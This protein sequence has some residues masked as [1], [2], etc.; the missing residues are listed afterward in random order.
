M[1]LF[2]GIPD[3]AMSIDG[4]LYCV[5]ALHELKY[6][7]LLSQFLSYYNTQLLEEGQRVHI[8][9]S[10]EFGRNTVTPRE[11]SSEVMRQMFDSTDSCTH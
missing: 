5:V 6:L 4:L 9:F 3:A 11:L 1:D 8:S 2:S 7:H 10:G